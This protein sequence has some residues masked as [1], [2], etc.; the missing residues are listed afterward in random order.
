MLSGPGK[1]NLDFPEVIQEIE[2]ILEKKALYIMV[3]NVPP[4]LIVPVHVDT[5]PVPVQRWHLP[6]QT[7]EFAYFWDMQNHWRHLPLMQWTQVFHEGPHTVVNFGPEPRI[8]IV[9]DLEK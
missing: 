1:M 2:G 5:L 8:H 4:G 3:N 9:V 6:V 7:N